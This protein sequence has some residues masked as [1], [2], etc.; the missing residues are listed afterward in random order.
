MRRRLAACACLLATVAVPMLAGC[1]EGAG[2][3]A[4]QKPELTVSAAASLTD[5]LGRYAEEFEPARVRLS[6][7]GSD[8]LA[9]QIRRGATPDVFAAAN[10]EL[11]EVLAREGLVEPPAVFATNR[12]V[13]AV[14]V[15]SGINSLVDLEG[16][17]RRLVIGSASVPVGRYTRGVLSRLGGERSR[18]IL[19]GVRSEEPD[20]KG[21]VAKVASRAA[22]A[23]FVYRSDV[24]AAGG[25]LRAIELPDRLKPEASY[26]VAIVRGSSEPRLAGE[27]VAGLRSGAGARALRDA[28]FGTRPPP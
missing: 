6:L 1:G 2:S 14:P 27:F 13:L 8:E 20:V 7:G 15:G 26:G 16:P 25:R 4:G 11:P 17:G 21:V 19:A 28:G 5:A 10:T 24:A 18:R 9:A 23:G 22:E 12:L 3:K